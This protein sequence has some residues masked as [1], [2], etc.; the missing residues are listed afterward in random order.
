MSGIKNVVY[1]DID[2][3]REENVR[4]GKLPNFVIPTSAEEDMEVCNLDMKTLVEGI[5]KIGMHMDKSDYQA[6]ED[7]IDDAISQLKDGLEDIKS[8]PKEED[9]D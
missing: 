6:I 7:T 2:T 5:L 1:V 4:L 3:D 8:S 9:N